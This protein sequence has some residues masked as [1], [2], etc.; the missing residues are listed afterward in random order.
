M[1]SAKSAV[2]TGG[3]KGT[4]REVARR[5]ATLG[6]DG[7]TGGYFDD[8]PLDSSRRVTVGHY[9]RLGQPHSV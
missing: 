1:I 8:R 9:R 5:V 3:N 7:P 2:V 6:A 4:G